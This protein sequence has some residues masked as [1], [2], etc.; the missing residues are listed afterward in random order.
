MPSRRA[1]PKLM[2]AVRFSSK[3]V[4]AEGKSATGIVV[5]AEAIEQLGRGRRP[6]VRVSVN[7]Y[8]FRTTIGSMGGNCMISVSAAIRK[9][10]GLAAG[11]KVEVELEFDDAPREVAVPAD[12]AKA[13]EAKPAAAAFFA[14][15]SNSLQRYHVDNIESAKSAETRQRRVEKAIGLFL[16]ERPR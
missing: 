10:S 2:S 4:G 8:E 11:D 14:T 6:A 3:L 1:V 16:A 13:L 9:A 15:L 12:L 7:G 5:P